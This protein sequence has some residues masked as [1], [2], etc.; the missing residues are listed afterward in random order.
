MTVALL[1]PEIP[2]VS[3]RRLEPEMLH[4][5]VMRRRTRGHRAPAP[6]VAIACM[7]RATVATCGLVIIV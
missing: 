6:P 3:V 4:S 1:H 2:V 7:T 5:G